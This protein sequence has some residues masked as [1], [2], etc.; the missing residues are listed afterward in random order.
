MRSL[1]KVIINSLPFDVKYE[2]FYQAGRALGV[3]AYQVQ[4]ASGPIFGHL[5]DQTLIKS[6]LR[7]QEWSSDIARMIW[8]A[9]E[10]G[11]GTYYDI[12][13]NVGTVIIPVAVNRAVRCV[14][15]EPDAGNFALLSANVHA[16]GASNI[17]IR[18]WRLQA[19]KAKCILPRAPITAGT[20]ICHPMAISS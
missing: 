20:I 7:D 8:T 2:M 19:R 17:E 10:G 13:A 5:Y 18:P 15:F 9:F 4:G 12:G 1:L 14:G 6:Y 16:Q 11:G 3:T